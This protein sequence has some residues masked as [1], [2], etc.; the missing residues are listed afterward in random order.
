MRKSV[1]ASV[2]VAAALTGSVVWGV[3]SN[4]DASSHPSGVHSQQVAKAKK[5]TISAFTFMP[6]TL[7]VSPG[8]KI[9]VTNQ[10][11]VGHTV[12]SD[13]GTSF[14]NPVAAKS[15][16]TFTAPM[17]PGKYPY[18]CNIHPSMHGLLVVK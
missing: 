11:A 14:N 9:K 15:T 10:D 3:T 8:A 16:I 4:A 7:K 2:G 18:H 17:T 5:I 6:G 1:I 12:T 13:D